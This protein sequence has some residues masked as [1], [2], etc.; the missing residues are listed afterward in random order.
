M[1]VQNFFSLFLQ[2]TIK[3]DISYIPIFIN[4]LVYSVSLDTFLIIMV[5]VKQSGEF[6][7]TDITWCV[8]A[9]AYEYMPEM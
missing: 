3:N 9:L 4:C 7:G 1:G 8:G 2:L 5:N 6:W